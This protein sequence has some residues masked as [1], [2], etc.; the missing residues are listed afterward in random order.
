MKKS[1]LRSQTIKPDEINWKFFKL[2]KVG[3]KPANKEEKEVVIRGKPTL[4]ELTTEQ[5]RENLDLLRIGESWF[6]S[7][8]N[9]RER[10]RRVRNY[11]R[12]KQWDDLIPDPESDE[13][14]AT[15]KE[16]EHIKRQGK[17][18]LKQNIMAQLKNNIIG[19]FRS[20]QLK[21]IV[22]SR[23]KID[24]QQGEMLTN[25][26]QHAHTI[27]VA[28]ELDA[29]N[30]QEFVM[31][32]MPVAKIGWRYFPERNIEDVWI[33]N[34]NPSRFFFN[35]D[36][37]DIRHSDLRM[38]GEVH[39]LTLDFIKSVFA[40]NTADTDLIDSWYSGYGSDKAGMINTNGLSTVSVDNVDFYIPADTN[41]AR[42]IE[43]WYLKAGWRT[44]VHDYLTGEQ[45]ITS[46]SVAEVNLENM[47][48]IKKAVA[49]GV[50][51][52]DVPLK[53]AEPK[54][55]Q[56]WYVKFLTPLGHCLYEGETNYKH[57]SHPYAFVTY[58]LV[59]GEVWGMFEE[60][61][62]QQR[63][64]NRLVTMMDFM[65]GASA[66]GVLLV[67]EDSIPDDMDLDDITQ[68]WSR[69]NGVIK[70]KAKAGQPLPQQIVSRGTS[71]GVGELLQLQM[72]LMQ[73]ISGVNYAIQGQKAGSSTPSSLYAQEAENSAVNSKDVMDT[74]T[75]YLKQRD[76]KLLKVISQFYDEKRMLLVGNSSY[77]VAAKEWNPDKVA[78]IEAEVEISQTID[79]PVFRQVTDEILLGLLEKQLLDLETYLE[80]S[81]MPFAKSLL[82]SI[83]RKNAA[84]QGAMEQQQAGM[85]QP[86]GQEQAM[87][88]AQVDPRVMQMAQRMMQP[89]DEAA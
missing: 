62:D 45:Y 40:K 67:P 41:K 11:L 55:E 4:Q 53:V 58:P 81:N 31:S 9:F 68:E 60:I 35:T 38:V 33:Q 43:I 5:Q 59:D 25:A 72:K 28:R 57:E 7:L 84:M 19:R 61:I 30:F 88:Q 6:S 65:I 2:S 74:Y 13:A 47:E 66:K 15:I 10:R 37:S 75:Y 83:Q 85:Q 16:E 32:G 27:N 69:Y 77:A 8:Y 21:P 22:I 20:N 12:G 46:Q 52:N 64:I 50:D 29:R 49:N 76:T 44:W 36:I 80:H 34:V 51:V 71:V 56:Y 73:E 70:I 79:T 86:T 63:Y 3:S 17:I 82:Q 18:P 24:E 1:E 14:G 26:L 87:P 48:R 42:V 89:T 23:D 54:Y 39:D 78:N